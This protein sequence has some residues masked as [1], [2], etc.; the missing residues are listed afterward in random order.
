[1]KKILLWDPRFPD[2]KPKHLELDDDIASAC[3]RA[4][5]AAAA[6]PAEAGA[7]AQGSAVSAADPTEIVIQ[8]GVNRTMRRVV[9][10]QAVAIL[11]LA[12]GVAAMAGGK[13]PP[14]D[15]VIPLPALPLTMPLVA[16]HGDSQSQFNFAVFAG[17][18]AT[19]PAPTY[20]GPVYAAWSKDPRF[21]MDT[22]SDGGDPLGRGFNGANQGLAADHFRNQAGSPLPGGGMIA[23]IPYTL[24]RKPQI[25]VLN[26]L[27]T[28]T[29]HS[30]DVDGSSTPAAAD[31]VISQ[32]ASEIAAFVRAGVYVVLITIYPR[33]WNAGDARHTTVQTVN[34]FIRAQAGQPGVLGVVDPYDALRLPG[35]VQPNPKYFLEEANNVTVHLNGNGCALVA[36]LINAVIASA[37]TAGARFNLNPSVSNL[38]PQSTYNLPGTTGTRTGANT[39]NFAVG[40]DVDPTGEITAGGV[41]TGCNIFMSRGGTSSTQKCGKSGTQSSTANKQILLISP[42]ADANFWHQSRMT[43]PQL[44]LTPAQRPAGSWIMVMVRVD[45]RGAKGPANI[46]LQATLKNSGGTVK[47]DAQPGHIDSLAYNNS[48]TYSDDPRGQHWLSALIQLPDDGDYATLDLTV[49]IN[50]RPTAFTAGDVFPVLIDMPM[51]RAEADPRPAWNL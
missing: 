35:D 20:K 11:A 6:D 23:R 22:W 37:T 31:Y 16:M 9:V 51:V 30:G 27:G 5:V 40:T 46:F 45:T 19:I 13:A 14:V 26:S 29:I 32:V 2:G 43:F 15:P 36:P 33:N 49:F 50:F 3:V 34:D 41:A 47:V 24:A 8:S 39:T 44:A 4:G 48:K 38:L 25:V 1:M 12:L 10:P 21:N 18:G 7:L 17:T 42:V 28:N